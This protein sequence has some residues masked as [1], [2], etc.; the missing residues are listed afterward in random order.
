M[1]RLWFD[2]VDVADVTAGSFED[3]RDDEVQ[4]AVRSSTG[5]KRISSADSH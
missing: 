4:L 3:D 2:E 5:F 1:R